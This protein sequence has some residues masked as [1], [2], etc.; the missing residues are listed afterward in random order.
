MVQEGKDEMKKIVFVL[1]MILLSGCTTVA[2]RD[3]DDTLTLKGI[4][5]AHWKDGTSIKGEPIIKFPDLPP[6][7]YEN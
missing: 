1:A 2:T 5:E 4:G 6:I 7:K 3:K